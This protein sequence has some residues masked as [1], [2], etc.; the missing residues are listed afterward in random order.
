MD[1]QENIAKRRETAQKHADKRHGAFQSFFAQI[2]AVSTSALG[3]SITF[4]HEIIGVHPHALWLL[5]TSWGC[6]AVAVVL[7]TLWRYDAVKQHDQIL[8][9]LV[10]DQPGVAVGKSGPI[11]GLAYRLTLVS[12]VVGVATLVAFAMTNV[13][14]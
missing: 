5:K 4:M 12:F 9:H 13:E 3:L 8:K 11:F 7:G 6:F 1:Q 10:N 14:T 2:V